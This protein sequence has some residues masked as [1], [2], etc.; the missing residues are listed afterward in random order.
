MIFE[1][2]NGLVYLNSIYNTCKTINNFYSR[3][4][5]MKGVYFM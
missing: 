5:R 2:I 3:Y 4:K 1:A